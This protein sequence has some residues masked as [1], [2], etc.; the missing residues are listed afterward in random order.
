MNKNDVLMKRL[1][2]DMTFWVKMRLPKGQIAEWL[3]P[4]VQQ[5][6]STK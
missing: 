3:I 5:A 2:D 4:T 1:Q 6:S